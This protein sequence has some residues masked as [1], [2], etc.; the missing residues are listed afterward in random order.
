MSERIR[1]YKCLPKYKIETGYKI[2]GKTWI[3]RAWNSGELTREQIH[4]TIAEYLPD[5]QKTDDELRAELR[6][7]EA[8]FARE[9][10]KG[11]EEG[12]ITPYEEVLDVWVERELY[13]IQNEEAEKAEVAEALQELYDNWTDD[14]D[15]DDQFD[16]VYRAHKAVDDYCRKLAHGE[17]D[18]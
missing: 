4:E 12:D 16:L 17:F 5:N 18:W 14:T 7:S 11:R 2:G 3:C 8:E 15:D 1:E 9:D 10:F 13:R 6:E